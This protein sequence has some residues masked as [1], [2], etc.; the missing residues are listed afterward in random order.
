M[1]VSADVKSSQLLTAGTDD[2]TDNVQQQQ[3]N[4]VIN[5]HDDPKSFRSVCLP[6]SLRISLRQASIMILVVRDVCSSEHSV[7]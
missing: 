4:G 7:P 2:D 3:M 5:G 1:T 6:V